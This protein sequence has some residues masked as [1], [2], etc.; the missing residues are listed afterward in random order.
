MT[1]IV[2][3]PRHEV[4]MAGQ[5]RIY[6]PGEMLDVDAFTAAGLVRAG[7]AEECAGDACGSDTDP[8]D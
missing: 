6:Y 5:E 1:R 7:F 8:I 3:L 2:V 4:R